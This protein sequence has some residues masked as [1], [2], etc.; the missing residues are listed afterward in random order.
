MNEKTTEHVSEDALPLSVREP[1]ILGNVTSLVVG[2][3][4]AAAILWAG[5]AD[6]R[7]IAGSIA[8]M[9]AAEVPSL[10]WVRNQVTPWKFPS[11]P[12]DDHVPGDEQ[13]EPLS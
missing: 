5:G 12:D 8:A 4:L 6:P 7:F 1:V 9:I 13:A 3:V 11:L 10:R 2:A